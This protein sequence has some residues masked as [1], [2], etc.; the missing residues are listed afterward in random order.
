[1]ELRALTRVLTKR[2]WLVVP[3]FVITLG[4]AVVFAIGLPVRYQSATTYV[5]ASGAVVAGANPLDALSIVSRQTEIVS[6]YSEVASSRE[7]KR[8]VQAQLQLTGGQMDD[9]KVASQ[10]VAGTNVL[11]IQIQAPT[12]ALAHDVAEA[13][14]ATTATYVNA[15]Y[16]EF[17]LARLDAPVLPDKASEPNVPLL[18]AL[19]FIVALGLAIGAAFALELAGGPRSAPLAVT[20]ADD[21]GAYSEA[22]LRVRL[23]EELS[24]SQRTGRP[25]SLALMDVDNG[26][27]STTGTDAERQD[28]MRRLLAIFGEHIRAEDVIAR[29][30]DYTFGFLLP[31]RD[32]SAAAVLMDTLRSRARLPILEPNARAFAA[33]VDPALG[34]ITSVG[35]EPGPSALIK[36]A[37]EAL[38]EAQRDP[39][40]TPVWFTV[41][42]GPSGAR[43]MTTS[44]EFDSASDD[45]PEVFRGLAERV[46]PVE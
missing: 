44:N 16:P 1:M 33:R 10:V 36:L 7:I 12:P 43:P 6:T 20:I 23:G 17:K 37:D 35:G 5:V 2:W 39:E 28:L 22:F 8:Q 14:G 40:H 34:G 11:Q 13:V 24:R 19:G 9:L 30:G 32:R 3:I 31:D 46:G 41:T 4:S 38:T 26:V 21:S 15:L 27:L 45:R 29:L 42:S 18:A 25:F